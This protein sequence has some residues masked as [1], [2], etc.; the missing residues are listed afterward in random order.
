MA[1]P[2]S[3]TA[4]VIRYRSARPIWDSETT[5]EVSIYNLC[6][7]WYLLSTLLFPRE[8]LHC[9]DNLLSHNNW[10]SSIIIVKQFIKQCKTNLGNHHWVGIFHIMNSFLKILQLLLDTIVKHTMFTPQHVIITMWLCYFIA[11]HMCKDNSAI[12]KWSSAF[13][14]NSAC[15]IIKNNRNSQPS[16]YIRLML[17]S[18]RLVSWMLFCD[19]ILLQ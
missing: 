19:E 17:H 7:I 15:V 1:S 6:L 8:W 13:F 14:N 5:V 10:F 3:H 12:F 2:D 4:P 18:L 16:Y 9:P 11:Y